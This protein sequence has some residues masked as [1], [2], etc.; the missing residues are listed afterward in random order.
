MSRPAFYSSYNENAMLVAVIFLLAITILMLL[1]H[2]YAKWRFERRRQGIVHP[3]S[4]TTTTPAP[5]AAAHVGDQHPFSVVDVDRVGDRGMD[6]SLLASLPVFVYKSSTG[7][8]SSGMV[9]VVCLSV[10]EEEEKGRMLPKCGHCFHVGC[11]DE[12]LLSHSSSC[13]I[14]RST[15]G[16]EEALPLTSSSST[17]LAMGPQQEEDQDAGL[18]TLE[19]QYSR[20]TESDHHHQYYYCLHIRD[21][22][23]LPPDDSSSSIELDTFTPAA[24][25]SFTSS[26]KLML[27]RER[28]ASR[29]HSSIG[30]DGLEMS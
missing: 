23:R 22:L 11:I 1:L 9:C 7:G 3:P 25:S 17:T 15:V 30:L 24:S 18:E 28:F 8:K 4:L 26:L 29:V 12:W 21:Q 19:H 5:A 27:S 14:C 6:P 2:F 20:T 16:T 13:P 10:M